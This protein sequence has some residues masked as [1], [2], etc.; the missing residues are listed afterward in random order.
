MFLLFIVVIFDFL[1][2]ANSDPDG[3]FREMKLDPY[4]VHT[5][6][7]RKVVFW[8]VT[9]VK[10]VAEAPVTNSWRDKPIV[11]IL[12]PPPCPRRICLVTQLLNLTIP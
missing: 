8:V 3:L 11:L 5:L 7:D 9:P 10:F 6:A 1:Q 12:P 2:V 4:H